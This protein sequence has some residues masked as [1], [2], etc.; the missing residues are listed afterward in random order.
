MGKWI[1]TFKNHR[2]KKKHQDA[3]LTLHTNVDSDVIIYLDGKMQVYK[4]SRRKYFRV[5]VCPWVW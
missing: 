2:R 3:H 5:S 1:M 4:T